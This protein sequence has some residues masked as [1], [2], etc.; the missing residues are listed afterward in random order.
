MW[1]IYQH[2]SFLKSLGFRA[3][4]IIVSFFTFVFCFFILLVLLGGL[5]G[6]TE[7]TDTT[8]PNY[9]YHFGNEDSSNKVLSLPIT[10]IILGD[11]TELD[12]LGEFLSDIGITYGYEVKKQLYDA[13]EN[14]DIKGVILEINSP[15]GTIYG[16]Q[17][18]AD[19]VAYYKSKTNKPVISFVSGVAAS[20]G[21]WSAVAADRVIA[22]HGTSVG[23]IGVITGPFKYF[24]TVVSEN[25][26]IFGAGILTQGGIE[27]SFITAGQHKDMGNPYRKMTQ[28]EVN[29]L[30]TAVNNEY[31]VFVKHVASRRSL[32]ESEVKNTIKALIY[33]P[34]TAQQ[35]KLI[36]QIANRETAYDAVAK[37]ANVPLER[38]QVVKDKQEDGVV[39]AL[40]K[41][42]LLTFSNQVTQREICGV[43][44]QVLAF[45]GNVLELCP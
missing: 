34:T 44:A 29:N 5:A 25:A 36:D 14:D 18:I 17:A 32:T 2:P 27:T 39:E 37:A 15:G 41:S 8:K 30:Q 35:L 9:E 16:S 13:A 26:G 38:Y 43:S 10:G 12:G 6:S 42:Q 28:D 21:Y 24:D 20:G 19:G 3:A 22:D 33:D 45:H 1:Q 7:T 11:K 4:S 23:S 31:D 40:F